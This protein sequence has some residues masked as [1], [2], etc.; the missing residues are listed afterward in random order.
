MHSSLFQQ[1]AQTKDRMQCGRAHN[2]VSF[3]F[4]ASTTYVF[5]FFTIIFIVCACCTYDSVFV[6]VLDNHHHLY[7]MWLGVVGSFFHF[8]ISPIRYIDKCNLFLLTDIS[9]CDFFPNF[10]F[11]FSSMLHV[12]C[13]YTHNTSQH[14][15]R[16][17]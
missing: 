17:I 4:I 10:N 14:L 16:K 8:F 6:C 7:Y 12:P 13:T 2:W 5:I 9:L 11:F 15:L 1:T 3:V